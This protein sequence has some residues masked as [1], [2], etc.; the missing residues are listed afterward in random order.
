MSRSLQS[1]QMK[2]A[3]GLAQAFCPQPAHWYR[4]LL[5]R[6]FSATLRAAFVVRSTYASAK[7]F[8]ISSRGSATRLPGELEL[9]YCHFAF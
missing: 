3:S 7:P 4:V 2:W 5:W 9:G 8:A 1:P 6:F